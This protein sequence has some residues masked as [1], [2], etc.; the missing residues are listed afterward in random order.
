MKLPAKIERWLGKRLAVT[1]PVPAARAMVVALMDR[2]PD[3]VLSGVGRYLKFKR[4]EVDLDHMPFDLP[5]EGSLGFEHLAGLFA[6]TTLDEAIVSM[7]IRQTAYLYGL[8]RLLK[9][10]KVIEIGRYKGGSTLVIAAA[11]DGRGRLWS[12]DIRGAEPA[13]GLFRPVD[14]QIGDLCQRL[15]LEVALIVGDSRTVKLETGD[16]DLVFIDGDHSYA[17]A[18]SD[19]ERFGRRVRVGGAVLFDDAFDDGL[20][21]TPHTAGVSRVVEEVEKAGRFRLVKRVQKL[22]HLERVS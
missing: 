2:D 22:A 3:P 10:E 11:M 17:G 6:S 7:S 18:R 8:V 20:L 16:V 12:I 14:A 1:L 19:F 9:P 13:H 21:E 5:A 4:G 15:G